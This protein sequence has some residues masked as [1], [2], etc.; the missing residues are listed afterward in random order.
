[1]AAGI[2]RVRI[3]HKQYPT[4][5]FHLNVK[6]DRHLSLG[7][8]K[9]KKLGIYFVRGEQ[10]QVR[11]VSYP[12]SPKQGKL[13]FLSLSPGRYCVGAKAASCFFLTP[14]EQLYIQAKG[15]TYL[16]PSRKAKT[17]ARSYAKRPGF[18]LLTLYSYPPGALFLNNKLLTMTPVAQLPVPPGT[19][20]VWIRN[21][22]LQMEH[23][24]SLQIKAGQEL[25]KVV[26]L[27]PYSPAGA[28]LLLTSKEPVE[29]FV[30][31]LYKGWTPARVIPIA[32]GQHKVTFR[33][34][35]GTSKTLSIKA[36]PGQLL[37]LSP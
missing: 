5:T 11:I 19:Y 2:H 17:N 31:G 21:G 27:R 18:G 3:E 24:F 16:L 9:N 28:N 26:Y 30:D 6:A 29:V 13:R 34:P 4:S 32:A 22:Y 7:R 1:M 37:P 12:A 20:K 36:A 14:G 33:F 25:R 23:R 15:S 35:K 8:Q 10:S